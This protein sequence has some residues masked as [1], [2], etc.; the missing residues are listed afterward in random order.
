[1]A[2][3]APPPTPTL[4]SKNTPASQPVSGL[5]AADAGKS[6]HLEIGQTFT[7]TLEGNPSTG[8]SWD[9]SPVDKPILSEV[10]DPVS[11][12]KSN[13]PGAPAMLTLTFRADANGAQQLMLIYHRPWE[14]DVPPVNSFDVNVIV[15]PAPQQTLPPTSTPDT[16]STPTSVAYPAGGIKGWLTYTST[17]YGFSFQY[18]PE[19]KIEPGSGTMTGHALLLKPDNLNAQFVV[20][21]KH[22]DE[23][24][25]IGRTGVGNGELLPR[26]MVLLDGREINRTVLVFNSKDMTVL[27]SCTGCMVRGKVQFNFDLDYL[28]NWTDPT[29]LTASVEAQADL[30]VASIRMK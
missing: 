2:L 17:D 6:I 25:Q 8:Y 11:A 26:G 22:S 29:A 3:T 18:P 5:V 21:F 23:D 10:G 12:P 15:G 30:I 4:S 20:A 7:V 16:R 1:M 27:Y 14:K 13:L 28:G 19:W 24:A 9:M